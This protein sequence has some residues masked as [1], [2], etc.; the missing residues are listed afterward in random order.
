[1]KVPSPSPC[2]KP[3]SQVQLQVLSG[4][5]SEILAAG[6]DA[7]PECG[8][9]HAPHCPIMVARPG[10]VRRA[11][12]SPARGRR[13]RHAVAAG[14]GGRRP[15]STPCRLPRLPSLAP[16]RVNEMPGVGTFSRKREK[17]ARLPLPLDQIGDALG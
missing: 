3:V 8:A 12:P 2:P 10:K 14:E 6:L 13:G 1:M 9:P 17:E 7:C 4:A 16:P 15:E 5:D 11:F